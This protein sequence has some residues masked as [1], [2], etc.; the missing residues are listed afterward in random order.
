[1]LVFYH[2]QDDTL[3]VPLVAQ[4]IEQ[5]RPKGEMWVR[6]LPRGLDSKELL[7]PLF[8]ETDDELIAYRDDGNAH[9]AALL[10]H[11]FALW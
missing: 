9:L 7:E 6:F 3:H 8:V 2:Q 5:S 1:M 10:Y 4:W 11:F